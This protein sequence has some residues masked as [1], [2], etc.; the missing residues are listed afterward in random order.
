MPPRS[1]KA[2]N[3]NGAIKVVEYENDMKEGVLSK[4]DKM[5]ENINDEV[6]KEVKENVE[7]LANEKNSGGQ[8]KTEN[9][10]VDE[11]SESGDSSSDCTSSSGSE[12]DTDSEDDINIIINKTNRTTNFLKESNKFVRTGYTSAFTG[13]EEFEDIAK[14]GD[15]DDDEKDQDGVEG[16]DDQND[17]EGQRLKERKED[18]SDEEEE[19]EDDR[20]FRELQADKRLERTA[21]GFDIQSKRETD[22]DDEPPWEQPNRDL[23]DYFNYG[24]NEE[25]WNEYAESQLRKRS[26]ALRAKTKELIKKLE[27]ERD[28]HLKEKTEEAKVKEEEN[29]KQVSVNGS[30]TNNTQA[31]GMNDLQSQKYENS[32]FQGDQARIEMTN[33]IY[34]NT[35]FS[36]NIKQESHFDI[37]GKP[38]LPPLPPPPPSNP[39]PQQY[40]KVENGN[41][42]DSP[43]AQQTF[44]P[45]SGSFIDSNQSYFSYNAGGRGFGR[46]GRR[47]RG[48]R[49][50][51]L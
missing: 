11:G 30:I 26:K 46:G 19:E 22:W 21:F 5:D 42:E 20:D 48:K 3:E 38:P 41:I 12:W 33:N 47:K 15:E 2:K 10:S 51:R 36:Q 13:L 27:K 45:D 39:P 28:K 14:D 32:Y 23:S 29:A 8:D 16:D 31:I 34:T 37:G 40:M 24:L 50:K 44:G 49:G 7:K 4:S 25:E 9:N 18:E 35:S 43:S 6:D 1:K 17:G